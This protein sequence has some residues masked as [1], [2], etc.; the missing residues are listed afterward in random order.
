[1]G[2]PSYMAPEQATGRTK[3]VGP[4]ADIYALGAI[5]YE[6]LTGR[7]PFKGETAMET[8]RLVVHDDP[9]PPSRLV[10]RLARDLET[11]CLKCLNKD[12][13][14][15]YASAE[16]LADDLDRYREGKPIKARPTPLWERGL[17]WSEA[18]SG[19][20]PVL[21]VGLLAFFGL[22]VGFIVYQDE[23][24]SGSSRS[25]TGAWSCSTRP[26]RPGPRTSSRRLRSSWPS[27][28]KTP[29]TSLDSSR[30]RVRVAAKQKWVDEQLQEQSLSAGG[31][32][33]RSR[34][35]ASG[36]RSSWSCGRR[37]SCT[38][39]A[40]ES[41]PDGPT[42]EAPC[43]GPC[44]AGHLR[45]GSAGAR[46][47]L[48]PGGAVAGRADGVPRRP[49]WPTVATTCCLILSQAADPAEGLRILD[50]AVQL[51]PEDDGRVPPP[52][53]R[54]P[55]ARGRPRGPGPR[56][57]RSRA[58]SSPR[59]RWTTSST[60]ASWP[61]AAGSPTPFVRSTRP[62]KPI[63]IRPRP[64]SCWRSATSTCNR[65]ALS[66]ARTSLTACIRSH[67]DLVGLYLMRAL[68]AGEEGNQALE[69]I[70]KSHPD[71]AEAARLRQDAK[72]A[73]AAAKADYGQALELKPRRRSS[74]R[75]A[76]PTAA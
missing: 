48:D 66:Q 24:N 4:A 7:P 36:F 67:P 33:T 9:V 27:F 73:I 56:E 75:P 26:T 51:R 34:R 53:R 43:L 50:R 62:C 47:R 65:S 32:A 31:P 61:S 54:L 19:R 28:L 16:E 38:R 72:E 23:H 39:R 29:R 58:G 17:K 52:P 59:P 45:P 22:S 60:V 6:V 49:G 2:T 21:A 37:P 20:R 10:P 46:R 63:P 8:V 74:I 18:A 71:E 13:Q 35:T 42:R 1:M 14:K 68:V 41:G 76:R 30:S 5:L 64:T 3:D 15:R 40:S 12:P 57:S 70:A 44:R 25:K 55:R 11:I 69:K